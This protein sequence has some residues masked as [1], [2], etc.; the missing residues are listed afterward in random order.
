M[1]VSQEELRQKATADFPTF[2]YLMWKYLGLPKPTRAQYAMAEYLQHG[3]RLRVL[4]AF[5]GIGKSWD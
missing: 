1:K 4:C 2:L 5:R 3:P